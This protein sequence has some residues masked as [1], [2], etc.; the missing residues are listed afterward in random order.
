MLQTKRGLDADQPR[1]HS[2]LKSND[3]EVELGRR[4]CEDELLA[5]TT[6]LGAVRTEEHR[7]RRQ[8][9]FVRAVQ[10]SAGAGVGRPSGAPP[11]SLALPPAGARSP[12][13]RSL[14][15]RRATAGVPPLRANLES[16]ATQWP[17]AGN[18][19]KRQDGSGPD[20]LPGVG[21]HPE[22]VPRGAQR[23]GG[24]RA[25]LRRGGHGAAAAV[26]AQRARA[27]RPVVSLEARARAV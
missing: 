5:P 26:R 12:Q 10:D 8:P 23:L 24:S 13:R 18:E 19:G 21:A 9:T 6:E 1:K 16:R 27:A 22:R 4:R 7:Y 25:Q 17:R 2:S 11:G 20:G 3:V 14:G 15:R